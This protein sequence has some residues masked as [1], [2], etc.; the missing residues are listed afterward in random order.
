VKAT[1][2]SP[3][4]SRHCLRPARR[5]RAGADRSIAILAVAALVAALSPPAARAEEEAVFRLTQ[6]TLTI[7][8]VDYE[9]ALYYDEGDPLPH[10][11]QQAVR[12]DTVVE[13][14]HVAVILETAYLRLTVL[15]EM[16]RVYAMEYKPTG[17]D[18]LWKNDI[19]RPG[20]GS[21]PTGWWLWIGGIEY[22]LPG[23]EHGT[24]FALPWEWEILADDESR[25]AVRLAVTEPLTG[26]REHLDLSVY[27]G[28][29][30]FEADIRIW[31]P[32]P[33]TARFAHWVNPMWVPGGHNELTDS[34]ELIIPTRR[35]L[36]E[37]RWQ[38]NLGPSPQAWE[39]NPLRFIR[40]WKAGDIMAD[41]LTAGYYSA[42]SHDEEEGVVRVFDPLA[43]PG[44]D[45]WT[46]GFHPKAI[47]TGS[48]TP[49]RGYAE[50][51]GGTTRLYP[52]QTNPL[53][54]GALVQWTEWMYPY[55]QT[56]GLTA[57][58]E[59]GALNCRLDTVSRELTVAFCPAR[60]VE[61]AVLEVRVAGRTRLREP[62]ASAP[63][64]PHRRVLPVEAGWEPGEMAV[65]IA[66]SGAPQL[67]SDVVIGP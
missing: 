23:E 3:F 65:I 43:T 6:T 51:W 22:T 39:G 7:P 61:E 10:L 16:G 58:N 20:G 2:P 49:S 46:Y 67:R 14:E 26:L 19:V 66:V 56:G 52:H 38:K 37:E 59:L 31:N 47:F 42:Y 5:R 13:K 35:V 17:H 48:G 34:T 12:W 21:N 60:S 30:A 15:P 63:D 29:A 62:F 9:G 36:V 55:Q 25:K 28:S 57:A 54:P 18:V 33:D 41:G 45:V 40:A 53:A 8:Q 4:R 50:M 64:R 11:N 1:T 27:P 44:V 24:T 32:T